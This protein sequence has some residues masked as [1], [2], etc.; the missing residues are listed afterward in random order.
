MSV[1][2]L[3]EVRA[4]RRDCECALE[5]A[6]DWGDVAWIDEAQF[7]LEFWQALERRAVRAKPKCGR[8]GRPLQS[9]Q[10]TQGGSCDRCFQ[11]LQPAT[12]VVEPFFEVV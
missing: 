5:A 2:S 4:A 10:E 11:L 3:E 6:R 8:C 12:P 9:E 7:E 1:M